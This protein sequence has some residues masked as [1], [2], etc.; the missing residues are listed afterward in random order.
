MMN[1]D[2]V[3]GTLSFER[4]PTARVAVSMYSFFHNDDTATD[5]HRHVGV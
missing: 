5:H 4:R 2:D 3:K 1:P